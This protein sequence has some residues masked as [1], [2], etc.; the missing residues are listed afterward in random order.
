MICDL[1]GLIV[2]GFAVVGFCC[3]LGFVAGVLANRYGKL[4]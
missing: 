4:R 3:V 1:L 2:D